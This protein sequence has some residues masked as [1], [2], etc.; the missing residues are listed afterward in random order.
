MSILFCLSP[1]LLSAQV[2]IVNL[3]LK[4]A[5]SALLYVGVSNLIEISGL[6]NYMNLELRSNSCKVGKRE[7]DKFE[8]IVLDKQQFDTLL[9][10]QNNKLLFT[11]NFKIEKIPEFKPQLGFIKDYSATISQILMNSKLYLV[12]P[13]C[14]YQHSMRIT[15]FEFSVLNPQ[16]I[17]ISNFGYT[18]GNELTFLQLDLIRKLKNGS[19]LVFENI[20][21]TCPNCIGRVLGKFIV[22]IN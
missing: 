3:S 22:T 20:K 5:D 8:I 7:N 16:N 17:L 6:N 15:S 19:K 2:R 4:H 21:A 12:L 1:Y 14:D 9:V 10:F 18:Y 11:K 13:N